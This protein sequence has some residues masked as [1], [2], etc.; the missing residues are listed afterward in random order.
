M[1]AFQGTT[2]SHIQFSGRFSR[3]EE[4]SKDTCIRVWRTFGLNVN[5]EYLPNTDILKSDVK[6]FILLTSG[7]LPSRHE[8][9]AEGLA[10]LETKR[11]RK[12][13]EKEKKRERLC[14]SL[15]IS[16]C[17]DKRADGR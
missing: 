2:G 6:P 17:F 15:G 5:Q 8:E 7:L 12:K 10:S 1:G 14:P 4:C 11:N 16:Y 3:T 13:I 9:V